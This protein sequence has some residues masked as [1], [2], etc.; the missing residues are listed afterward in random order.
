[1]IWAGTPTAMTPIKRIA[2]P[3]SAMAMTLYGIERKHFIGT[4]FHYFSSEAPLG[5]P[6]V[7]IG[8]FH[9]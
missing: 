1:M 4:S 3:T 9:L 2:V 8:L 5:Q 6:V 7:T